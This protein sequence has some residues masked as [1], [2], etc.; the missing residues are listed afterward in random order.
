M[1]RRIKLIDNRVGIAAKGGVVQ[2]PHDLDVLLR[3]RLPRQPGGFVEGF[4]VAVPVAAPHDKTVPTAEDHPVLRIDW[5]TPL[6]PT[7]HTA[8]PYDHV[9]EV[10]DLLDV[11]H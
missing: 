7:P 1:D 4:R 3:H 11:P 8:Q 5:E 6:R 2:L 9:A 10:A